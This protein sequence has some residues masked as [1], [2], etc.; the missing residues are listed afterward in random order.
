MRVTC[1]IL[2]RQPVIRPT[3]PSSIATSSGER[4]G[5]GDAVVSSSSPTMTHRPAFVAES[6][7]SPGCDANDAKTPAANAA[8][9]RVVAESSDIDA[10]VRLNTSYD[11]NCTAVYGSILAYTT[12]KFDATDESPP[13]GSLANRLAAAANESPRVPRI[14]HRL[15][16][17]LF[18]RRQ[19]GASNDFGARGARDEREQSQRALVAAGARAR[20]P[21][22]KLKSTVFQRSLRAVPEERALPTPR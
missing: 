17:D 4:R 20:A 2:A 7:V 5:R 8:A 14:A 21:L 1:A 18:Q 6:N 3:G 13:F 12:G 9:G 10:N 16:P 22:E 15:D 19:H 11:T